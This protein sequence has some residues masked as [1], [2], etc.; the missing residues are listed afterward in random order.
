MASDSSW[1][2]DLPRV[3]PGPAPL[4]RS[5]H[6]IAENATAPPACLER[7]AP[8]ASSSPRFAHGMHIY[9]RSYRSSGGSA[10]MPA[11]SRPF[12]VHFMRNRTVPYR[13][14]YL[15]SQTLSEA[16]PSEFKKFFLRH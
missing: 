1:G 12:D 3:R 9:A 10:L 5:L 14:C 7:S 16:V 6:A 2:P 11:C 15:A 8:I 13:L 4:F